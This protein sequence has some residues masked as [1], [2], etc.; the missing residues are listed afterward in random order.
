MFSDFQNI[1]VGD[2][3]VLANGNLR[4]FQRIG[5]HF[6]WVRVLSFVKQAFWG[7]YC[8]KLDGQICLEAWFWK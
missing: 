5:E 8:K 3:T 1:K 7:F 6:R 4:L 2:I